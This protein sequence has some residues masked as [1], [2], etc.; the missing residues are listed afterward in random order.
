MAVAPRS[1]DA[2]SFVTPALAAAFFVLLFFCPNLATA[3]SAD[4]FYQ[5]GEAPGWVVKNEPDL[6]SPPPFEGPVRPGVFYRLVDYQSNAESTEDYHHYA[7]EFLSAAGVHEQSEFDIEFDPAYQ[8]LTIHRILRHRNGKVSDLFDPAS[9]RVTIPEDERVDGLLDG[10]LSVMILL[11]DIR[12]GDV[13]EYDYTLTGANPIF[14]GIFFDAIPMQWETTVKQVSYR[15]IRAKNRPPL[16][17]RQL[18]FEEEPVRRDLQG[19]EDFEEWIWIRENVGPRLVEDQVPKWLEPFAELELTEFAD[20]AEVARWGARHYDFSGQEID[21]ELAKEIE[22]IRSENDSPEARAIAA[23]RFVQDEIRYLGIEDGVNAFRPVQPNRCFQ[24]RF[25]DCKDKTVLLGMMLAE[26]G[27]ASEPVCVS[28]AGGAVVANRL[29]SPIAFDHVVNRIQLPD[30]RIAWCDA[31][32]SHQG[33]GFDELVFP[34]YGKGL[35]I[36]ATTTEL[37]KLPEAEAK[38]HLTE[39]TETFFLGDIGEPSE[40]KIEAVYTG[41]EADRVRY[42]LEATEPESLRQS[43]LDYYRENHVQIEWAGPIEVEDDREA[44]RLVIR[45]SYRLPDAWEPS[46]DDEPG[47]YFFTVYFQT[48]RDLLHQ[49]DHVRRT[50]PFAIGSPKAARHEIYLHLPGTDDDWSG[51]FDDDHY[52]ID[53]PVS[54]F[55]RWMTYDADK[56][57]A[58]MITTYQKTSDAVLPVDLPRFVEAN[59]EIYDLTSVDLWEVDEAEEAAALGEDASNMSGVDDYTDE[60]TKWALIIGFG[61]IVIGLLGC[62]FGALV[63]FLIMRQRRS[64]GIP[65]HQPSGASSR[66]ATPPPLPRASDQ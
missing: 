54:T 64:P 46:E 32:D 59:R 61:A 66:G 40:L 56:V 33:G 2:R 41:G 52:V 62:G 47:W 63:T 28:H 9:I 60:D 51:Y 43:Y 17:F 24:K 8:K 39:V 21:P 48:I 14:E 49:P 29:P 55:E 53:S 20:W 12:P 22:R 18:N 45:E 23:I 7:T 10:H 57:E 5:Q 35:V 58:R 44:N 16:Q 42:H 38:H 65:A 37:V 30:G 50:M 15:L 6:A 34:N 1:S 4:E 3:A 19:V 25:G 27:I 31:T 11:E 13:V 36:D 26:L